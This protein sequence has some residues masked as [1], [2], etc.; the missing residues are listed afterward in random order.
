M[1]T[2]L[3]PAIAADKK[4]SNKTL[5]QQI[6]NLSFG[7]EEIILLRE[8]DKKFTHANPRIGRC[9]MKS[10]NNHATH[11]L[12]RSNVD[13]CQSDMVCNQHANIWMQVKDLISESSLN[14]N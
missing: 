1:F 9:T 7:L 4:E 11:W 13:Y 10:C 2:K 3:Q 8:L 6:E 14:R 12:T 5:N